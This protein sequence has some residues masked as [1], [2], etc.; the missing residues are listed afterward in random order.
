MGLGSTLLTTDDVLP[1][2]VRL[3]PLHQKPVRRYENQ[4]PEEYAEHEPHGFCIEE[5]NRLK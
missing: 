1:G 2:A 5:R 4:K 3:R